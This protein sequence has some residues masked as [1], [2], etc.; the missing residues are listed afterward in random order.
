MFV[1]GGRGCNN[2][3]GR[4]KRSKMRVT[5]IMKLVMIRRRGRR[6]MDLFMV[7]V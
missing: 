2:R 4:E 3:K 6:R 5:M 7:M 1:C